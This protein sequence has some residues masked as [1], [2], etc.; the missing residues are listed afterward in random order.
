MGYLGVRC[1]GSSLGKGRKKI[2]TG[3]M[4]NQRQSGISRSANRTA[5]SIFEV[6]SYDR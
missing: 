1:G 5:R 2:D 6:E 3:V 4:L